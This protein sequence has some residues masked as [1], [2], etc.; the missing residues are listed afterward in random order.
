[1]GLVAAEIERAGVPTVG[2]VYLREAAERMRPPRALWVPFPHG[3]ALGKPNDVALQ[4]D[5]LRQT[6]ALLGEP[7]PGPVLKDYVPLSAA[8]A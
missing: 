2:Q 3:Y 6:F 4:L 8:G 5:V 7:G 1:V